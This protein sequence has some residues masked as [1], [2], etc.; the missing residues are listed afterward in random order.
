M[1]NNL[2]FQKLVHSSFFSQM[3]RIVT[4][5]SVQNNAS[6]PPHEQ[7][8]DPLLV[9]SGGQDWRAVQTCSHGCLAIQASHS[10]A[11]TDIWYLPTEARMVVGG[12]YSTG[13]LSCYNWIPVQTAPYLA[14]RL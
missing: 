8:P 4:F 7:G 2:L 1:A 5:V 10:P 3:K 14:R 11:S 9:T 12:M 6:G 13:M